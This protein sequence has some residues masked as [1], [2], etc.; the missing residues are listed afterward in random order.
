MSTIFA[1]RTTAVS[2]GRS[3]YDSWED[4]TEKIQETY[5]KILKK[6]GANANLYAWCNLHRWHPGMLPFGRLVN[7]KSE[8]MI[9]NIIS[10]L[11]STLHPQEKY[12]SDFWNTQLLRL[13][14]TT[15]KPLLQ[16]WQNKRNKSDDVEHSMKRKHRLMLWIGEKPLT[17]LTTRSTPPDSHGQ[18]PAEAKSRHLQQYFEGRSWAHDT[19]SITTWDTCCI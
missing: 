1:D 14:S 18:D 12:Y 16:Y 19:K 15:P 7:P 8:Q 9:D 10:T 4:P 13:I 5:G 3:T 6:K 2:L 17:R 11:D